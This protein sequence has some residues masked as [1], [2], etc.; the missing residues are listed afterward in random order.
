M[1]RVTWG[2]MAIVLLFLLIPAACAPEANQLPTAYIDSIVPTAALEGETITFTGHGT[3][4]DG[5]V[6]AYRWTSTIDGQIGTTAIFSTSD[7]SVGTHIISFDVQDNTGDRSG[8]VTAQITVGEAVGMEEAIDVVVEDILPEIPEIQ[9]GDPYWCLKL[10]FPLPPGT[11]IEEDSGDT[12]KITL[13]EEVFFFYLD[14]APSTYYEHPVKYIMVDNEGNHEEYDAKWWPRINDNVLDVFQPAVPD[15]EDVIATNVQLAQPFGT[16]MIFDFPLLRLQW[17]EGFIVVQGLMTDEVL[18][19]DAVDTYLNGIAF[20]NGYKND[21]SQVEGLVQSQAADV[22]DTIDDMVEDGL[23]P[24]T[25]YIIAHGG[26]D[27]VKLGGQWFTATQ[28]H[29]KMAEYPDTIFNF[30]LGS[31][32]S[33]SFIDNLDTLDNVCVV[34]TACRHDQGATPD[35][36]TAGSLTDF[37][38]ADT[39]SEWTGSLLEAMSEIVGDSAKFGDIREAAKDYGVPETCVL[40]CQ[41]SYGALGAN[42]TFG[43]TQDLDLSHRWGEHD[44]CGYCS[45]LP[46]IE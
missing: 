28:F 4:P 18:Y 31:C 11:V 43:L 9:N 40:I 8:A 38:S 1:K 14:L 5:T 29:N 12:L 3:D 20:F 42:P 2:I 27:S 19:D 10:D 23:N 37:N 36:D 44:P 30:I 21:C 24:I 41:A 35:W 33:G 45:Y 46:L 22:L 17:C 32:H 7:L 26:T 39:G 34:V 16:A 15:E 6:V 13:E 25:I